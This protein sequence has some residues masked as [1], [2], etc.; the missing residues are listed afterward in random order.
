[1]KINHHTYSSLACLV[2]QMVKNLPAMK[3]TQ[4]WS[5]GLEDPLEKGMATHSSILTWR[6]PWTEEP[7]GLQCMKPQ[8][9]RHNWVT[10][11]RQSYN[12]KSYDK[13]TLLKCLIIKE[14]GDFLVSPVVK[15]LPSSAEGVGS[16]P[17]WGAK[18][19]HASQSKSQN[20]KA[21]L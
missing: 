6:S 2:A 11:Y 8:R 17:G 3:A 20:I 10:K 9:I 1:M 15:T 7:G 14:W 4:V 12:D 13:L 21:I 19:T 5:L 16:I 18:I